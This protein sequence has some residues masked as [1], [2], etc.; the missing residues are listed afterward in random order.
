[1]PFELRGVDDE[2][3]DDA[4][5]DLD[6]GDG[7]VPAT[8]LILHGHHL[9]ALGSLASGGEVIAE[10]ICARLRQRAGA[11]IARQIVPGE[12]GS[13]SFTATLRQLAETLRKRAEQLTPAR[14]ADAID[15]HA[16]S[17]LCTRVDA[18]IGAGV[19]P[20]GELALLAEHIAAGGEV[21][22]ALG[23]GHRFS[24]APVLHS[25][26]DPATEPALELDLDTVPPLRADQIAVRVRHRTDP[27][28]IIGEQITL[29]LVRQNTVMICH[30]VNDRTAV[31]DE[32]T[33][34]LR[35]ELG[36]E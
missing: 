11:F 20:K 21:W 6:A 29:R 35:L 22:G 5:D 24:T 32:G 15:G 25:G 9:A 31:F 33:S 8:L 28:T 3:A 13:A 18:W 1:M 36:N 26:L 10:A 2:E 12:L 30:A 4:F 23:S 14:L 19:L 27:D 34:T 7:I 17:E 16:A